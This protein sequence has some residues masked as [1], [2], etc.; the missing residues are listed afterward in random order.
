MF[1]S[2]AVIGVW[3]S[4]MMEYF[5]TLKFGEYQIS[6]GASTF[7]IAAIVSSMIAGQI[8]DRRMAS[9]RL[10]AICSLGASVLLFAAWKQTEFPS[11]WGLLLASALLASP[12]IPLGTAMSFRHLENAPRNFP[13][14]RVWATIGWVAGAN[15]LSLWQWL[16]GRGL[17]DAMVLA[18]ALAVVNAAYCLTLPHTPPMHDKAGRSA[19]GKALVMLRDPGFALFTILLFFLSLFS[20]S[21]YRSI[22]IFIRSTGVTET[23]LSTVL[24]TGQGFEIVMVFALPLLYVRFGAK[25]TIALGISAWTARFAIFMLGHPLWFMIVGLAL[26]G[27]CFACGRIA[28]TIYVDRVCEKDARASAQSLLAVTVDG[29]GMLLGSLMAGAV[30]RHYLVGSTWDWRSIWLIPAVGCGGVLVAF[31]AG[32]RAKE[33]AA[34]PA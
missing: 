27:I 23:W 17:G 11:L 6:L 20:A 32:F 29:A 8:A 18:S 2:G 24:S 21:Y 14:V 9:E 33:P 5:H 3:T 15:L 10:M 25:A 13:L 12:V 26:H 22:A 34:K 19:T 1:L 7:P 16:T 31:V 28:A 30:S 4:A